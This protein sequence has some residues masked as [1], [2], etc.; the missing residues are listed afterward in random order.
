MDQEELRSLP[1]RPIESWTPLQP[2]RTTQSNELAMW[3]RLPSDA[4]YPLPSLPTRDNLFVVKPLGKSLHESYPGQDF[5][6]SESPT[7]PYSPLNDPN[8]RSFFRSPVKQRHLVR[9]GLVTKDLRV[10]TRLEDYNQYRAYLHHLWCLQASQFI[11]HQNIKDKKRLEA[12]C[13]AVDSENSLY[14]HLMDGKNRFQITE[15]MENLADTLPKR[16][17]PIMDHVRNPLLKSLIEWNEYQDKLQ[18]D[19]KSKYPAIKEWLNKKSENYK[20]YIESKLNARLSKDE[21]LRARWTKLQ[22]NSRMY[23]QLVNRLQEAEQQNRRLRT[24]NREQS[25]KNVKPKHNHLTYTTGNDKNLE[26]QHKMLREHQLFKGFTEIKLAT[27]TSERKFTDPP[28][29]ENI[30]GISSKTLE[31]EL[32]EIEG[33]IRRHEDT[34]NQSSM[35]MNTEESTNTETNVKQGKLVYDIASSVIEKLKRQL[36]QTGDYIALQKKLSR[37][38]KINRTSNTSEKLTNELKSSKALKTK[39]K[40]SV[41][42]N[43]ELT[44]SGQADSTEVEKIKSMPKDS[45]QSTLKL[46]K[47]DLAR[48]RKSGETEN[49]R[50]LTDAEFQSENDVLC[51]IQKC[52]RTNK[53]QRVSQKN[54]AENNKIEDLEEPNGIGELEIHLAEQYFKLHSKESDLE[55]QRSENS[56]KNLHLLQSAHVNITHNVNKT[57]FSKPQQVHLDKTTHLK[58][59]EQVQMDNSSPM[60][61]SKEAELPQDHFKRTTV[62]TDERVP[63]K[64]S[65]LF[66]SS[67]EFIATKDQLETTSIIN[68]PS[69]QFEPHRKI[70]N[71]NIHKIEKYSNSFERT[72]IGM[73][74]PMSIDDSLDGNEKEQSGPN[75]LEANCNTTHDEATESNLTKAVKH[76]IKTVKEIQKSKDYY[77]QLNDLAEDE[78]HLLSKQSI[79]E[80]VP[81]HNKESPKVIQSNK[82]TNANVLKELLPEENAKPTSRI[83]SI[84]GTHLNVEHDNKFLQMHK[85]SNMDSLNKEIREII[86]TTKKGSE[87]RDNSKTNINKEIHHFRVESARG[88]GEKLQFVEQLLVGDI[89]AELQ[90]FDNIASTVSIPHVEQ[91]QEIQLNDLPCINT[92]TEIQLQDMV[93][94][95]EQQRTENEKNS[96]IENLKL[97]IL[98]TPVSDEQFGTTYFRIDQFEQLTLK[99][100]EELQHNPV[101]IKLND[102]LLINS[103]S[104]LL[105]EQDSFLKTQNYFEILQ[106]KLVNIEENAAYHQKSLVESIEA[107]RPHIGNRNQDPNEMELKHH[108]EIDSVTYSGSLILEASEETANALMEHPQVESSN[109]YQIE[110]EIKYQKEKDNVSCLEDSLVSEA[111]KETENTLID[112]PQGSNRDHIETEKEYQKE[113]DNVNHSKDIFLRDNDEGIENVPIESTKVVK[114]QT[115]TRDEPKDPIREVKLQTVPENDILVLEDIDKALVRKATGDCVQEEFNQAT[116]YSLKLT[117]DNHLK[118]EGLIIFK[119]IKEFSKEIEQPFANISEEILLKDNSKKKSKHKKLKHLRQSREIESKTESIKNLLITKS[120]NKEITDNDFQNS[121]QNTINTPGQCKERNSTIVENFQHPLHADSKDI[122]KTKYKTVPK[123][124]VF[125]NE[126][127]LKIAMNFH[128]G[129]PD[130]SEKH[131]ALQSRDGIRK[132]LSKDIII[133]KDV[134]LVNNNKINVTEGGDESQLETETNLKTSGNSNWVNITENK[135]NVKLDNKE[136]SQNLFQ[137]KVLRGNQVKTSKNKKFHRNFKENTSEEKNDDKCQFKQPIKLIATME[138]SASITQNSYCPKDEIKTLVPDELYSNFRGEKTRCMKTQ[139]ENTKLQNNLSTPFCKQILEYQKQKLDKDFKRYILRGRT[140]YLSENWGITN[141]ISSESLDLDLKRN[142]FEDNKTKLDEDLTNYV[143]SR[144]IEGYHSNIV[145]DNQS[146]FVEKE[147]IEAAGILSKKCIFEGKENLEVESENKIEWKEERIDALCKQE[148]EVHSYKTIFRKENKLD[149]KDNINKSTDKELQD[150]KGAEKKMILKNFCKKELKIGSKSGQEELKNKMYDDVNEEI[151]TNFTEDE[152]KLYSNAKIDFDKSKNETSE[153]ENET[154]CNQADQ[155]IEESSY[156][157]SNLWIEA[158][159]M[160]NG[161]SSK[162]CHEITGDSC[163]IEECEVKSEI[164]YKQ[165]DETTG[166]SNWNDTCELKNKIYYIADETPADSNWIEKCEVNNELSCNPYVNILEDSDWVDACEVKSEISFKQSNEI[167]EDSNSI[168]AR[169]VKNGLSYKHSNEVLVYRPFMDGTIINDTDEMRNGITSYQS[170]EITEHS[171]AIKY[172][173]RILSDKINEKYPLEILVKKEIYFDPIISKPDYQWNIAKAQKDASSLSDV[174]ISEQSITE[175]SQIKTMPSF[176]KDGVLINEHE[177]DLQDFV[178]HVDDKIAEKRNTIKD[179]SNERMNMFTTLDKQTRW[180]PNEV[181]AGAAQSLQPIATRCPRKISEQPIHVKFDN[182]EDLQLQ[183]SLES[184]KNAFKYTKI[185]SRSEVTNLKQDKLMERYSSDVNFDRTVEDLCGMFTEFTVEGRTEIFKSQQFLQGNKTNIMALPHNEIVK[186]YS[187]DVDF[188]QVAEDLCRKFSERRTESFTEQQ[189]SQGNKTNIMALP[190]HE[191]MKRHSSDVNFDQVVEDLCRVFS[192]C[193]M[194][195]FTEQQFSQGNK[196]NIM[197]LPHHEKM[198]IHTSDVNFDQVVEDLCRMFSVFTIEGKM[199]S[200][201]S[202]QHL[203]SNETNIMPLPHTSSAAKSTSIDLLVGLMKALNLGTQKY[204]EDE[205]GNSTE[206]LISNSSPSNFSEDQSLTFNLQ[207]ETNRNRNPFNARVT[208]SNRIEINL[209]EYLQFY[210]AGS[211][212]SSAGPPLVEMITW[213]SNENSENFHYVDNPETEYEIIQLNSLPDLRLNSSTQNIEAPFCGYFGDNVISNNPETPS[214]GINLTPTLLKSNHSQEENQL[215][216]INLNTNVSEEEQVKNVDYSE[217]S[218]ETLLKIEEQEFKQFKAIDTTNSPNVT[219]LKIEKFDLYS[220]IQN[221]IAEGLHR[222]ETYITKPKILFQKRQSKNVKKVNRRKLE[223]KIFSPDS[224]QDET[225]FFKKCDTEE[226]SSSS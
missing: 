66:E 202:R 51:S 97:K 48:F 163:S 106:N 46:Q 87:T 34:L 76:I 129:I 127:D 101:N 70:E 183:I 62:E 109:P 13:K 156:I 39:D 211:Q 185:E 49:T 186:K 89:P 138:N 47:I 110:T 151:E 174:V 15:V 194:E 190:H 63:L 142:I 41:T 75:I 115:D 184:N 94:C 64:Q 33:Q 102:L 108:G 193:R 143:S 217:H 124:C 61:S 21:K 218:L 148:H 27:I 17:E 117:E 146:C 204:L 9:R 144:K 29:Q 198:E 4:K 38:K 212:A 45:K 25:H 207:M 65:S 77:V 175:I 123:R 58:D 155:I 44:S 10:K 22:K 136:H 19:Y 83:E 219:E 172:S 159:K 37:Q 187:L 96:K 69:L 213:S 18:K 195:S 91:L 12:L 71:N 209:K 173:D 23:F 73:F 167:S 20:F 210:F 161:T 42:S 222:L 90:I 50:D 154:S 160:N 135:D 126:E 181:L 119:A 162:Q 118:A 82:V 99:R 35:K 57:E 120:D 121:I 191:K 164:P 72:N 178:L 53:K 157:D 221:R 74:K 84:L 165:S 139:Q 122:A 130:D 179:F 60:K 150:V 59:R 98:K 134:N 220:R 149:A 104:T 153:W 93:E 32:S 201:T 43:Y 40:T 78:A 5:N 114:S 168:G 192:E 56:S 30:L 199:E 214:T 107:D 203:H 131:K 170:G 3:K 103:T 140:L 55:H 1:R 152:K 206:F 200:C 215:I 8:L 189:F 80:F 177:L 208:V 169:E 67:Q 88:N 11:R 6:L 68:P 92:T 112:H 36:Q 225:I 180:N 52:K 223:N 2:K 132:D 28:R 158:S 54:I 176:S 145:V 196:T 125:L 81:Q 26:V 224:I 188:D 182:V 16:R 7:L 205:K 14:N 128:F 100:N 137:D 147:K 197:A 85:I 24:E 113:N 116:I 171:F 216:E 226:E 166:D 133:P 31:E 111:G 86:E 95:K 141:S 105:F 79:N